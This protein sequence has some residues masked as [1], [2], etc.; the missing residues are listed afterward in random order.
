MKW[1]STADKLVVCQCCSGT[2]HGQFCPVLTTSRGTAVAGGALAFHTS[3]LHESRDQVLRAN[4]RHVVA[5]LCLGS[6][7]VAA[8]YYG[9]ARTTQSKHTPVDRSC[10]S[11]VSRQ[12]LVLSC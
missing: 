4:G 8:L 9:R 10:R 2:N 7:S 1:S 6:A 5:R 3:S 11:T 12:R